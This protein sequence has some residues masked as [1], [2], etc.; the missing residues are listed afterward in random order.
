MR[1]GDMAGEFSLLET[2]RLDE[3][4]IPRLERHLSRMEASARHFGY[5][6]VDATIQAAV[7]GAQRDHPYGCWRLRLLV[8]GAGVPTVSC[9]P[10]TDDTTRVWRVAFAREPIDERDPFLFNKTTQRDVYEHARHAQP[11]VDDVILWNRRGEVTESTIANVV[12]EIDGQ[13]STPPIECGLL[14]GVFRA[15]LLDAG[16]LRERTITRD[17]FAAASRLWLINS[18]RGWIDIRFVTVQAG[19]GL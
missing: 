8:D 16:T 11:L 10:H 9:S 1:I 7:A 13:R 17:E 12:A 15:E 14:G 4:H 19:P 3:G 2:M 18:L 5:R 6:W